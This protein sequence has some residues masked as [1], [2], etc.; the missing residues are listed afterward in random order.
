MNWLLVKVAQLS[1]GKRLVGAVAWA[2]DK[3]KG[4][5]SEI[6]LGVMSLV[7]LLKYA[8]VID[9]EQAAQVWAVLAPALVPT[10]LDKASRVRDA[11]DKIVP[12]PK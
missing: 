8:G 11:L 7:Y 9:A 5:R 2:N 10:L 12:A 6:N 3:L 4:H 1:L